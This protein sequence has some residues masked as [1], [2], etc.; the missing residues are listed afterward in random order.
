MDSRIWGTLTKAQHVTLCEFL[1]R[2]MQVCTDVNNTVD[3]ADKRRIAKV[4]K[5]LNIA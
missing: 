5:I 3:P 4:R 1:F 2:F